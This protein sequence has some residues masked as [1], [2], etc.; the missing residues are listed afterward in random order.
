MSLLSSWTPGAPG[1]KRKEDFDT[2]TIDL[3]HWKRN[4]IVSSD[5][6]TQKDC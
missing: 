4:G 1:R 3:I 2:T 5:G 6:V